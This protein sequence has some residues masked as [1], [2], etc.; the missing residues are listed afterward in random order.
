MVRP[1][2]DGANATQILNLDGLVS[3]TATRPIPTDI[4]IDR[5][6][7]KLY[8]LDGKFGLACGPRRIW[9][10]NLDGSSPELFAS[11]PQCTTHLY[12]FFPFAITID[13]IHRLLY[14]TIQ[15]SS[16]GRNAGIFRVNIDSDFNPDLSADELERVSPLQP[17]GLALLGP[18]Q[19]LCNPQPSITGS[20]EADYIVWRPEYGV[21]YV[22]PS[23]N[24]NA[25]FFSLQWGLPGDIPLFGNYNGSTSADIALFRPSNGTWH[26]C[27]I[28]SGA[29]E[30]T[31]TTQFGLPDDIPIQADFDGDELSD[32]AVW[33]PSSGTW[34]FQH[35]EAGDIVPRTRQWGLPGDFPLTADFDQDNRDDFVV[36]RPSTGTWYILP[37]SFEGDSPTEAD[38]IVRQWGLPQ[39]YPLIADYD[40]DERPTFGRRLFSLVGWEHCPLAE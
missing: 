4:S 3:E 26:L 16:T 14:V 9:R 23:H 31:E 27:D 1:N 28:A 8:I 21:W 37:A 10:S 29:C 24:D 17:R 6:S 25:G 5:I 18:E 22:L 12:P 40:G 32:I 36:F 7:R 19:G 2:L 13:P 35:T 11:L 33:R 30:T 39:D 38:Y 34:Y 15:G 20:T